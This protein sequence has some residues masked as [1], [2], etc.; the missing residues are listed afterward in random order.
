[1]HHH[2]GCAIACALHVEMPT[3]VLDNMHL[4]THL[5]QAIKD[6]HDDISLQANRYGRIQGV[7]RHDIFVDGLG[8][9]DW[10]CH[11]NEEVISL[12]VDR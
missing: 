9:A 1:M 7:R 11:R 12:L 6:R 5:G 2:P 10:L 4:I 3:C 8:P